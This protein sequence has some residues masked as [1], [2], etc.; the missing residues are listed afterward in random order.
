MI[1]KY[2]RANLNPSVVIFVDGD[3]ELD[4]LQDE[5]KVSVARTPAEFWQ[6]RNSLF[7][8]AC[9]EVLTASAVLEIPA[10]PATYQAAPSI[11]DI[12]EVF[13]VRDEHLLVCRSTRAWHQQG[14]GDQQGH[15]RQVWCEAPTRYYV[16]T[17]RRRSSSR[18]IGERYMTQP[19]SVFCGIR[20]AYNRSGSCATGSVEPRTAR[21]PQGGNPA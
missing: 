2:G 17:R 14:H 21:A 9:F 11:A 6:Q 16:W 19:T 12:L 20:E 3:A 18:R 1:F 5:W 7:E 15:D 8:T 10:D 4:L 13:P